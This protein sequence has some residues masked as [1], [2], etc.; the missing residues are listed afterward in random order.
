VA[1][2]LGIDGMNDAD[3]FAEVDRGGRFVY[4]QYTIS[5]L[6]LTFRRSSDIFF[7]REGESRVTKGLP[8][9]LLTL[10]VGW[11]GIPWGP[12]YTIGSF[13]KNF[14]GGEDVTDQI[15][16]TPTPAATHDYPLAEKI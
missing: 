3:I 1:R 14:G 11:W 5:I 12:I 10:I 4:Y 2:I 8:Y 7:I 15:L 16:S 6:I 9:S 13:I